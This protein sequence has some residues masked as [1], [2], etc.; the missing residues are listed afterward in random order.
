MRQFHVKYDR[1][2]IQKAI[3][4]VGG[5]AKLARYLSENNIL[6]IKVSNHMIW[7]LL[8]KGKYMN[9]YTKQVLDNLLTKN[10]E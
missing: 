9:K 7:S 6:G 5:K 2:D 8:N 1:K 3:D 10:K 4:I